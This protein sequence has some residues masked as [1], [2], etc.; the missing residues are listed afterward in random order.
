MKL[1]IIAYKNLLRNTRRT[2]TILLTI[3][4][5]MGALF[6]YHGFNSGIMNQYKFNCI[7]SRYG[8]GQINLQNYLDKTYEKPWEHWIE[9]YS[10]VE[11]FLKEQPQ[12]KHVFPRL[13]FFAL[14]TNGKINVSGRGQGIDGVEEDKFFTAMNVEEGKNLSNE[15]DGIILGKGLARTLNVGIGD[16]VTVLANT[17]Y[18]SLNGVDLQVV[19]IFHTGAKDFDDV[20][21]RL[22]LK[23][24]QTLLD[25]NK[26]ESVS[27]G[28]HKD[29]DWQQISTLVS[30]RFNNLESIPF[31]ILDKVYY[32]HAVDFLKAQFD[33]IKMIILVIIILGIFNTISTAVLERKQEIGNLRANGESVA[34]VMK[35]FSLEGLL[36]GI[37][38]SLLGLLAAWLLNNTLLINGILMP[39]SPGITR[40]FHVFVELQPSYAFV[41]FALGLI[42]S[43]IATF[44]AT[45]KVARRPIG[46][47]L[48]SH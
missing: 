19:G 1:I 5:G 47:L 32:K 2:F 31:E 18:G 39:P 27:L 20:V 40:Q 11:S 29:E 44:L 34:D 21:F 48:R 8:H 28:L 33:A 13:Q 17:V 9:N 23:Q 35:L 42:T 30:E 45:L 46:E 7:R 26:V 16:N 25:T 10:E 14:L 22:Q 4:C 38:G 36:M 24:A 37:I 3:T 43:F 12:V 6:L 41:T 15:A